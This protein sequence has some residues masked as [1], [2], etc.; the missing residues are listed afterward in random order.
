LSQDFLTQNGPTGTIRVI[1][2]SGRNHVF[3]Y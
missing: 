2:G 1:D 3:G